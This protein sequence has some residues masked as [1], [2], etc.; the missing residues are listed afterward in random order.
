MLSILYQIFYQPLFNVFFVLFFFIYDNI[1]FNDFGIAIIVLTL[2]VRVVLYP[3]FHKGMYHQTAMQRL[4]PKIKEVQDKHKGNMQKQTEALWE[5]YREHKVNPFSG[6]LFIIIQ[7]PIFIAMY[8][9]ISGVASNASLPLYSFVAPRQGINDMFLGLINMHESSIFLIVVAVVLQF[10]QAKYS[11]PKVSE[12]NKNKELTPQEQVGRNMMYIMP[13]MT[14]VILWNFP[15][16]FALY[17]AATAGLSIIQQYF[18]NKTIL[19]K[20]ELSDK[21]R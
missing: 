3:L 12:E 13:G 19:H 6:L 2:T 21:S 4:S 14:A 17:W 15:S 7:L 9:L 1:S 5:L 8:G 18:V 11:L 20:K 10:F 16:A